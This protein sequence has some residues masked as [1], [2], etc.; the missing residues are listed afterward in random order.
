MN[1]S[2]LWVKHD[3]EGHSHKGAVY[4]DSPVEGHYMAGCALI[5][6]FTESP[7]ELQNI[8]MPGHVSQEEQLSS[9]CF[10][11]LCIGLGH[12]GWSYLHTS[13]QVFGIGQWPEHWKKM[14]GG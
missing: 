4:G 13:P 1:K 3:M 8:Q 9:Q 12:Q 11:V 6:H 14:P 7:V 2:H 10:A 5:S